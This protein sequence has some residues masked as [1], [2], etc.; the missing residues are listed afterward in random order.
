MAFRNTLRNFFPR[1]HIISGWREGAGNDETVWESPGFE[2]PFVELTTCESTFKP[3]KEYH[4]SLDTPELMNK[5]KLNEIVFLLKKII[6]IIEND[7]FG[8]KK[9]SRFNLFI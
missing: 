6:F 2:I 9:F 5:K 4:S 8:K 3:F 7:F 1:D